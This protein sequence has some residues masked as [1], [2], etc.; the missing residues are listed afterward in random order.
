MPQLEFEPT[1]P[2]FE[3]EKT[4][5]AF[6][7]RGHCHRPLPIQSKEYLTSVET[8]DSALL[9]TKVLAT[10]QFKPCIL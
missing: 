5:H 8:L 6:R 1:I 3:R 9:V 7:P 4:D 2:V 10:A